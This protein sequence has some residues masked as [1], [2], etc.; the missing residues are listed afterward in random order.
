MGLKIG[1]FYG[2]DD[3]EKPTT[4]QLQ[5]SGRF[6]LVNT[7]DDDDE[8][9]PTQTPVLYLVGQ[10]L[11]IPPPVVIRHCYRLELGSSTRCPVRRR[12][13]AHL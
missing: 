9:L 13:A 2:S 12:R 1:L 3:E 7:S 11:T 6:G 4:A 10:N 5:Q 8:Q